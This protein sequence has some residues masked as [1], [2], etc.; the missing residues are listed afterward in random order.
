MMCVH[1]L[2]IL[3]QVLDNPEVRLTDIELLE[4]DEK[5]RILYDFNDTKA[6]YP[7]DKTIH[8]LFEE[9]VEKSPGNIAVVFGEKKITYEELN[10][11]ANQLARVLREKGV[12]SN[13]I[14]GL[15]VE[16]SREML[17]G[18]IAILK[19]GGV[20]LPID[21]EYPHDRILYMLRDSNASIILTQANLEGRATFE[22][23]VLLLDDDKLYQKEEDRGNLGNV[24]KPQDLAYIMYTSGSAG[25]PKGVMIEHKSVV[26]LIKNSNY[27][28]FKVGDRILQTGA[29]VFDA[30]TFEIWGAMLNGLSLYLV[31][32]ATILDAIRLEKALE[33]NGITI[34][35][36]T[37]TLFNQL[38]EQKPEI[39]RSL[40]YLLVG[41]DVLSPKYINLVRKINKELTVINGYGPTENTTFSSC[42]KIEKDYEGNI[43][44]GKPISN[45]T[46]YILDKSG[47]L[48]PVGIP[49]EL[50]VGGDGLAR[51]YLNSPELTL[52]K[53]VPNPYIPDER[54]YRTGDLV[55]WL[56][57]GNLEF[58]GRIDHQVKISGYRIELEE[59]AARLLEHKGI[60]DAVVIAKEDENKSKY[61]CA[62]IIGD[63][64][65]KAVELRE[66]LSKELPDYMVPSYF[67]Q[68]DEMPMTHNGKIDR[69]VLPDPSG[70]IDTGVVYE[71]PTNETE[72]K[73]VK[74][75]QSVLGINKI[76][77]NDNFF[78]LGGH[79]LKAT[80][81][82]SR[83]HKEMDIEL[84]VV[85]IF[86]NNTIKALSVLIFQKDE[87]KKRIEEILKDVMGLE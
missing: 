14:V 34:L 35:W 54:M 49:G 75:W 9:Q 40:R 86:Q 29:I 78:K 41:G 87:Q 77:I 47:N 12:N 6:D 32:K 60:K 38:A 55:R 83:I 13:S 21:P 43:P 20:Y 19:A 3:E 31:E 51:G 2:K 59:I 15:M 26:R 61:L 39:F 80:I 67:L 72:E 48:V 68:L 33:E 8:Q 52:D 66:F 17:I 1:F 64:E 57:D 63:K 71:A 24:T 45:S 53:F 56:L 23:E 85:D 81:L 16:R 4:E 30:C 73:L 11:K 22:G 42:F 62:Y 44:I 28:D 5:Q 46:A 82:T 76:G 25:K 74:V 65:F 7:K 50:C 18:I 37:S 70:N 79:S 36:L 84:T 69:K 10:N 27:I 58:L